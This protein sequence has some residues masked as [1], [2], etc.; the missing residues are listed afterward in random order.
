MTLSILI[1]LVPQHEKKFNELRAYLES[2]I[3][4]RPVEILSLNS[5][6]QK[7]GGESTGRKRQRLL[8]QAKGEYVVYIDADDWVWEYYV[9]EMLRACQSGA[10]CFAINGIMTTDGRDEIKW[11]ISKDNINPGNIDPKTGRVVQDDYRENG[12]HVY[13]RKT[14]HITGVKRSIALAAGFPDKSNAEDKYY[15]DRLQLRTEFKIEK[16]LYHYRF[17]T[18]NKT[19]K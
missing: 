6:S 5:K 7:E 4:D 12:K 10:D 19:Y 16:P 1:P 13:L 8:E 2:Q 11:R 14:N 18:A 3:K 9:D 17:I 15:S